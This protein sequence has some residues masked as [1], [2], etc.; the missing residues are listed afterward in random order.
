MF[1][2][3]PG[4]FA[5]VGSRETPN[6][7]LKRMTYISN[8]L[9]DIGVRL[10]SGGAKG[11][12]RAFEKPYPDDMKEIFYKEDATPDA[13]ELSSKFH[14]KWKSLNDWARNLHARNAMIVLGKELDSPVD[15]VVCW[16]VDGKA[17]GGTGQAIRIAKHY[18]IPIFNLYNDD[19]YH[20]LLFMI[21]Q[22]SEQ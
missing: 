16:T 17:T 3:K 1:H 5:G 21:S 15:F 6:H 18:H 8:L 22:W 13:H 20:E 7:I 9:I 11:A 4:I 2:I 10:R 14:P 19:D 12:D